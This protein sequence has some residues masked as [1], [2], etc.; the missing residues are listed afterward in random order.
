[1]IEIIEKNKEILAV[2][3][4]KEA[5]EEKELEFV[6][7][8]SFSLQA[9]VHNRKKGSIIKPHK[10]IPFNNIQVL[11]TQEFFYI[12]K[13]SVSVDVY[14]NEDNF[15]KKVNLNKGD[16]IVLNAPHSIEFIKK[17]KFIE[18][19]QGPYRGKTKEKEYLDGK[20]G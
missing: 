19:K 18:I 20:D 8:D 14:D 12:E 2:V 10:H 3:Y 16:F 5:K 6:T 13:G 17:T 11:P 9:G 15:Y 4:R 7:P 1:M